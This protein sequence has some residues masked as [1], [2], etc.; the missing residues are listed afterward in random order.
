MKNSNKEY[1]FY[2]EATILV[3][4]GSGGNG[5]STYKLGKKRQDGIPDGGDGGNGG[6]VTLVLDDDL[7]TLAGLNAGSWRPN[8]EAR[9]RGGEVEIRPFL[10]RAESG[11]EGGRRFKNGRFGES[12][13]VRVPRGTVVQEEI[14]LEVDENYVDGDFIPGWNGYEYE[15]SYDDNNNNL[16]N[17]NDE[18][19]T[20]KTKIITKLIDLGTIGVQ[21]EVNEQGEKAGYYLWDDNIRN[22]VEDG[23][24]NY[25]NY[26]GE[27][28]YNT[29]AS[30]RRNSMKGVQ[31]LI[32]AYG[33]LGG[34]GSHCTGSRKGR[35]VQ[36]TR[37][38]P[39]PG[40]RKRLKL[41]LK[42]VADVA[43][44]GAPNVGKSTMLAAVTRAKPKIANYPFTTVIPNLGVWIP[45]DTFYRSG[46]G[47]KREGK[48][49]N[50]ISDDGNIKNNKSSKN[51]NSRFGAGSYGLVLCDVPGLIEGAADGVGLGHAFLRHVERCRVIL[52]LID[53][54]SDD[55][56][57]DLRMVNREIAKYGNGDLANTPQ[58]VAVNKVDVAFGP[59]DEDD[60]VVGN[61]TDDQHHLPVKRTREELE[62]ELKK[63]M[64]HSRLMWMSAKEGDGVDD[65]M[66]R[67]SVFVSKVRDAGGKGVE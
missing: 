63:E 66:G 39:E 61:P 3:R 28:Y 2:D 57:G 32:V 41:T 20:R 11:V 62:R 35:G 15:G 40:G 59:E 42:V 58:V 51:K 30:S 55:P 14:E 13:V 60:G 46:G 8:T 31:E 43:L 6:D 26:D 34:E 5:A 65:L 1:S 38:P 18:E 21:E 48:D 52:H 67:M 25:Y 50:T 64:P 4:A 9:G 37:R 44:V 19:S 45:P 16:E 17:D 54:T 12:S 33:G 10:F 29:A 47:K 24:E 23:D 49:I 22:G 56:V 53:A 36:R 7:N 27:D